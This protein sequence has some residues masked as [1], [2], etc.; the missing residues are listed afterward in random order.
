VKPDVMAPGTQIVS[1]VP[2]GGYRAEQGTSMATPHVAGVVALMWSANPGLIGNV[3]RTATIL[4]STARLDPV[5]PPPND[6][7]DP[8]N[9]R[10][11]GLVD[12]LAAVTA[13]RAIGP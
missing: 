7:G 6:C 1:A 11:A 3:T 13:A 4:R 12:A 9:V 5:V 10:G 2:G 8:R